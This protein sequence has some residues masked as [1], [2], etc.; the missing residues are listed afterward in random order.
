MTLDASR[1]TDQPH[2][3]HPPRPRAR[4]VVRARAGPARGPPRLP[5]RRARPPP[6]RGP[7]RRRAGRHGARS[8]SPHAGHMHVHG[9]GCG[10]VA[11]GAPEATSTSATASIATP[12]TT[13]TTTSTDRRA[14]VHGAGSA[15]CARP[16]WP[17]HQPEV[18]DLRRAV[19]RSA[20]V[21]RPACSAWRIA[22]DDAERLHQPVGREHLATGPEGDHATRQQQ[23]LVVLDGLADV[24]GGR[25]ERRPPLQLRRRTPPGSARGPP[26]SRP[27]LGSSSRI[28]SAR[29]ASTWAR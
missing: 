26:A 11:G 4:P 18:H 21:K 7:R 25:D 19:A 6:R 14:L 24:V 5:P 17:S 16:G 12:A 2:D 20:T 27:A 8:T 9:A 3:A 22:D 23:H 13:T 29:R 15:A 1:S 10:H 28:R